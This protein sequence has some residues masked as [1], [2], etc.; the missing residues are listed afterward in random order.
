MDHRYRTRRTEAQGMGVD[1]MTRESLILTIDTIFG[2]AE[3]VKALNK[4]RFM[5]TLSDEQD[6]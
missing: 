3:S 6:G 5:V 4:R 2:I 1:G